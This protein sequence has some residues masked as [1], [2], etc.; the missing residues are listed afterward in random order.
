MRLDPYL[1]LLGFAETRD[2]IGEESRRKNTVILR[3]YIYRM[4][5]NDILLYSYISSLLS[6]NQRSYHLQQMGANTESHNQCV[7]SKRLQYSS[8]IWMSPP[9]SSPKGLV[10]SLTEEA[11]RLQGALQVLHFVCN[12]LDP[13]AERYTTIKDILLYLSQKVDPIGNHLQMNFL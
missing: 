7:E 3:E 8:L 9:N 5:P 10:K 12:T 4:T 6:Q 2:N 11:E 13:T 1:I